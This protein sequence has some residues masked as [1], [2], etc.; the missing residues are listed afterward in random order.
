[1]KCTRVTSTRATIYSLSGGLPIAIVV[2]IINM[3]FFL[4]WSNKHFCLSV[5]IVQF[6]ALI[7]EF[8]IPGLNSTK[9]FD[10]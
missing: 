6:A 1:M 4:F 8:Y 9:T 2:Y 7:W 10:N 3:Y 5:C